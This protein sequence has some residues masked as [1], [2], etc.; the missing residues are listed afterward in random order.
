MNASP[1]RHAP[2]QGEQGSCQHDR[3]PV[4]GMLRRSSRTVGKGYQAWAQHQQR[5]N[6][7]RLRQVQ[8][9]TSFI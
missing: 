9:L 6:A 5:D 8:A 4:T 3:Q 2:M 1:D 7:T